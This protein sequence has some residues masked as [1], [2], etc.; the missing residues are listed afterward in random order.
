MPTDVSQFGAYEVGIRTGYGYV[1][2]VNGEQVLTVSAEEATADTTTY[3]RISFPIDTLPSSGK[4]TIAAE[5]I[6]PAEHEALT[7]DFAGF[8]MLVLKSSVRSFEGVA[9]SDHPADLSGEGMANAFDGDR[10]TKWTA[11][12][13]PAYVE[14]AYPN[15]RR[16]FI[17]AYSISTSGGMDTRRPH[18]WTLSG[19]NDN[20]QWDVLDQREGVSFTHMYQTMRF[21]LAH[22]HVA[23]N[24][25]RFTFDGTAEEA[26]EIGLI[27]LY[28]DDVE[29][30]ATPV[31][32]YPS[33][34]VEL[35]VG[36][37]NVYIAPTTGGFT[38]FA[39]TSTLPA[40]LTLSADSGVIYGSPESAAESA[41][42][43][44]TATHV[45]TGETSYSASFTL[46]V[47]ACTGTKRRVRIMKY[48]Y[49]QGS[50]DRWV[51]KQGETV[52]DEH[53]GRDIFGS[54][55]AGQQN[56]EYCLDEAVYTLTLSQDFD[57]GWHRQSYI[58]VFVYVAETETMRVLHA[59]GIHREPTA[60]VYEFNTYVLSDNDLTQWT[61][62]ADG[63][64][65]DGWATS[66]FSGTWDSVPASA[67]EVSQ[68]VWLFRRVVTLSS[69]TNL[70]GFEVM[71]YHRAGLIFYV[72][73]QEVFRTN[74]EGALTSTSTG[75]NL[76]GGSLVWTHF[77][78]RVGTG[79][80]IAGSNVL[81]IAIVNT[82]NT[83]RTIDN[84][85]QI[86]MLSPNAL[87]VGLQT[88]VSDTHHN[89]GGTVSANMF[90]GDY[91]ARFVSTASQTHQITATFQNG[92]KQYV[93]MYCIVS[94]WNALENSPSAWEVL[95]SETGDSF[96]SVQTVSNEYFTDLLQKKCYFMPNEVSIRAIRFTFTAI[97]EPSDNLQINA[98]DLYYVD[99][100]QYTL[101]TFG[102]GEGEEYVAYVGANYYL[103]SSSS[104][105]YELTITPE[106]PAGL[107]L[108]SS[109]MIHG[110]ATASAQQTSYTVS[111]RNLSG[112]P[113]QAIVMLTVAECTNDHSLASMSMTNTNTNGKRMSILVT[114]TNREIV[115]WNDNIPDYTSSFNMGF[116]AVKGVITFVLLDRSNN[117]WGN[118]YT[119]TAGS[120]VITG[121]H[122]QGDTP[123][124]I[125]VAPFSYVTE[126]ESTVEFSTNYLEN[127]YKKE[128]TRNW[129]ELKLN[130]LPPV[131]T[132]TAFY[133]ARFDAPSLDAIASYMVG[134]KVRGG[135]VMYLNG[136]EVNRV[137]VAEDA[138]HTT[139][140]TGAFD[141]PTYVT[142]GDSAQLS[143]LEATDN[144]L[145]VEVHDTEERPDDDNTFNMYVQPKMT[146]RDLVAN[147]EGT[148][149]H[150]GYNDQWYDE[151][152]YHLW[153]KV[154]TDKFFSN[155]NS[156]TNVW[157]Q[158]TFNNF[159]RD[160]ATAARVYQGNVERRRF[161]SLRV[162]ATNN[163]E[164]ESPVFD[165]L[166]SIASVTWTNS[167]VDIEFVPT[168]PYRAYRMVFNGCQSEG[169]EVGEI[170][171]Y[172]NRLQGDVCRPANGLPGALENGLVN[173]PCP[174]LY[175][176]SVIFQ[177]QGG[178]FVELSQA[179]TAAAPTLLEYD[180]EEYVLYTGK[181]CNIEPTVRG[182][183]LTF[184]TL[185]TLPAGLT[186]NESTGVISGKP[187][188]PQEAR[189]YTVTARNNAGV[190]QAKI[191]ITVVESPTP[192]WLYIVI[193]VAVI[194]VI[195]IIVVLIMV[196]SKKSKSK[197]GK[198]KGKGKNL[199]KT[200][201]PAPKAKESAASKNIFV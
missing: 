8:A 60:L 142:Y 199:P 135:F 169:I 76:S 167:Y 63:T 140:A 108:S 189:Q 31:L 39:T 191:R 56:F 143:L 136:Q 20:S 92:G 152:N 41:T 160:Y 196:I 154:N 141:E 175:E 127:W 49:W 137:R 18:K 23:Y 27:Q 22:N 29:Y 42:I 79:N 187:T 192:V 147:G 15:Q 149:S 30:V 132:I 66:D 165:E 19:S 120:D 115:Y 158:W 182:L 24:Q 150:V 59:T 118:T 94:G 74:V 122:A 47:V 114:D 176:G 156:C 57:R 197:K 113:A 62:K 102:F 194:V 87:S 2:Y 70:M 81:G 68:N 35:F 146:S 43:S 153:N 7:D 161:K 195:A 28:L 1:L 185:P 116:C 119:I 10:R 6:F 148:A 129:E 45:T 91:N 88:T 26:L 97:R 67:P 159:G 21:T 181:N 11:M 58:D 82:D 75:S 53:V 184:V 124:I 172:S 198:G 105:Y 171:F 164:D 109:G 44:I 201:A 170:Y 157:G 52:I 162:E 32:S 33:A 179:C 193:V 80:L 151:R 48:D 125:A 128:T 96:N 3:H 37:T 12:S 98:I 40:G 4:V 130:E 84:I 174:D 73:G 139:P 111:G 46:S 5:V 186:I 188:T 180:Q 166:A 17:N 14:L 104:L 112:A 65:P 126:S 117:P 85:F 177:C 77:S 103:Q 90:H 138:S 38:S 54:Q 95:V 178:S 145:C 78:G 168:K 13:L 155:D 93:N 183:E 89:D 16:D 69:I 51:L 110:K 133:C 64:I 9:N 101:P 106:L 99:P 173:G 25:Y 86:R 61:Y 34:T 83:A 131:S 50:A 71:A 55:A 123:R 144:L 163:P 107:K 121:T 190:I 72:N 200:A 100:A 134:V 36:Q